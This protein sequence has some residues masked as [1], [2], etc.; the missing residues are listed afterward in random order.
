MINLIPPTK[1]YQL[2]AMRHNTI[3]VRY[4]FISIVFVLTT[5]LIHF[6]TFF[7][8][9]Q[10]ETANTTQSDSHLQKAVEYEEIYQQAQEYT[11]N[12]A[13]A[14]QLFEGSIP[15][16]EVLS[17]LAKTLP[18]GVII[19][20]INLEAGVVDQPGTL[21]AHAVSYDA[22]VSLKD[23]FSNST[24]ARD[25]SIATVNNTAVGNNTNSNSISSSS[26]SN[27][28]GTSKN[29]PIEVTINITFT[30]EFLY[31]SQLGSNVR[32][33]A[34]PPIDTTNQDTPEYSDRQ[35]DRYPNINPGEVEDNLDQEMNQPISEPDNPEGRPL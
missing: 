2:K 23:A 29:Y 27:K 34:I 33:Q 17:N 31:P 12:L 6:V 32:P 20:T 11:K 15:Y 19:N 14:K 1:R 4:A 18:A 26:D 9:R 24:L 5:V 21:T 8:L 7:L 3:L 25:V 10:T 13:A 30:K 35:E 16:P 22:A 28:T